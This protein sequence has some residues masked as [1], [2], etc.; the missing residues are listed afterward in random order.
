[1]AAKKKFS[2]QKYTITDLPPKVGKFVE[3]YVAG[4]MPSEAARQAGYDDEYGKQLMLRKDVR[5]AIA[6][7]K[8][9]L[10]VRA[11]VNSTAVIQEICCIAFADPKDLFDKKGKK[12]LPVAKMPEP[13]RRAI[14]SIKIKA[15]AVEVRFWNKNDALEKLMNYLGVY[16]D[17]KNDPKKLPAADAV[18]KVEPSVLA[19]M[20]SELKR[21]L[22]EFFKNKENGDEI[23][24]DRAGGR[25]QLGEGEVVEMV[26]EK[27]QGEDRA[28]TGSPS[29]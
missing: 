24:P 28:E 17:G 2:K 7:A 21:G 1:M 4:N 13:V 22:L 20:P 25:E 16:P 9:R 10:V 12:F 3:Y 26:P 15:G 6:D 23:Q 14:A 19:A 18:R 5:S 29:A 27:A 8:R 11:E